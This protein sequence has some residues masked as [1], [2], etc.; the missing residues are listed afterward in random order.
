[1][2]WS[3][4][5]SP[6]TRVST[7][8]TLDTAALGVLR[9]S[10]LATPLNAMLLDIDDTTALLECVIDKGE[11]TVEKLA[12][13]TSLEQLIP[14]YLTIGWLTR[15]GFL[16]FSADKNSMQGGTLPFGKSGTWKNLITGQ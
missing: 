7:N 15:V 2:H 6:D 4:V 12:K 11:I 16:K 1:M 14:F 9:R 3:V 5:P 8:T 13:L 10:K